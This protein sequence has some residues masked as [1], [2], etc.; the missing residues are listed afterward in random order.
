M[1]TKA[2]LDLGSVQRDGPWFY[3]MAGTSFR[4]GSPAW[5]AWLVDPA[6]AAFRVITP[7]GIYT[8]RRER[9]AGQGGWYGYRR[10]GTHLQKIYIGSTGDLTA[11]HLLAIGAQFPRE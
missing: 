6:H 11:P 8:V 2:V 10:S 9:R 3:D 5:E 7:H 1:P 4:L